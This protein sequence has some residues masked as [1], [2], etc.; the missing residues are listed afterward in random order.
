MLFRKDPDC[1]DWFFVDRQIDEYT[2]QFRPCADCRDRLNASAWTGGTW[3]PGQLCGEDYTALECLTEAG[4]LPSGLKDDYRT[5]LPFPPY[6]WATEINTS[7]PDDCFD[8]PMPNGLTAA[9]SEQELQ[10]RFHQETLLAISKLEEFRA[11]QDQLHLGHPDQDWEEP[12]GRLIPGN[13]TNM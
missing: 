12:W 13:G 8:E 11:R 5:Y 1:D 2:E 7:T 3:F 6:T 9:L 4:D 10:D